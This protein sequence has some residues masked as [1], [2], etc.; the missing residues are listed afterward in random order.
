MRV[1][2]DEIFF[3]QYE[4]DDHYQLLYAPLRSY[5][6]L[7]RRE[8]ETH[9][10]ED[11]RRIVNAL[12]GRLRERPLIDIYEVHRRAIASDPE[13]VLE[14]TDDCNLRCRY[15]HASA[16]DL[17]KKGH[18]P[19]SMI[20]DVIRRF[21]DTVAEK[22]TR[23]VVVS[24]GGGEPTFAVD[25][26]RYAVE[27]ARDV[28]QQKSIRYNFRMATNGCFGYN[29][30]KIIT[31]NPFEVSLSFDGPDYIQN[32]HRPFA[33][34]K[35]SFPVVYQTARALYETG[36]PFS[37]RVTVSRYSLPYLG[38]IVSFFTTNF[39]GKHIGFEPLNPFGR[40]AKDSTLG[41]PDRSEFAKSLL[42][43]MIEYE[44]APITFEN[45]GVGKFETLRT[46]FCKAVALPSWIVSTNGTL[47]ACTRDN[48]PDV[49]VIG[50][51]DPES[52]TFT[53]DTGKVDA[54]RNSNVF[55]FKQCSDCFC[56]YHCAGDCL[57]LRVTGLQECIV[58]RLLGAHYLNKK[59][60][61]TEKEIVS[62][63]KKRAT[64]REKQ[65][66]SNI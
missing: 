22:E 44:G 62:H 56:K 14:L 17:H 35:A 21:F 48:A 28:A 10:R 54:L 55:N 41:V 39:P 51:F 19:I 37:F 40:G 8:L 7:V 24:F 33:D 61:L 11:N 60:R 4:A 63:G 42:K 13:L 6:A 38:E 1:D 64:R 46:V 25:A 59:M 57:D 58:N 20:G 32:L 31:E 3:V 30:L 34:G 66:P 26:F 49:F 36:N 53:V 27:L 52:K 45:A 47:S 16:G 65:V 12:L 50:H 29:T 15:C 5:L 23:E 43:V 2:G 9:I 18:M